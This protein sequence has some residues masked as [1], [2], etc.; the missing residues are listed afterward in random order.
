MITSDNDD[1]VKLTSARFCPLR[2]CNLLAG[3]LDMALSL[4]KNNVT[5]LSDESGT[6]VST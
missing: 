4:G 6:M 2:D 3:I 1:E 5:V